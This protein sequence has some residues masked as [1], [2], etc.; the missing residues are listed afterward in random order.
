MRRTTHGLAIQACCLALL[1]A[2]ALSCNGA[3]R[4][5][6]VSITSL[7]VPLDPRSVE[8]GVPTHGWLRPRLAIG[9]GNNCTVD[10]WIGAYA[11]AKNADIN[12]PPK[13]PLKI[14]HIINTG[15]YE[16]EMYGLRPFS[17]ASYDLIF[18][19]DA[20]TALLE[21]IPI[22]RTP[23]AGG[24]RKKGKPQGCGHPAARE[25]DADFWDCRPRPPRVLAASL[26][27]SDGVRTL[28]VQFLAAL[29]PGSAGAEDPAWFS[30]TSGCCTPMSLQ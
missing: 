16:T 11:G 7:K 17:R 21:L 10:V 14:A 6:Y 28:A 20:D 22:E 23:G 5:R 13:V 25:S 15:A 4:G 12:N 8:A 24:A 2:G 9:C 1:F 18:R 19:S 29:K 26:F 27:S 30:C 3:R